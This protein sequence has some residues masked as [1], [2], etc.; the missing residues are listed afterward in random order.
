[1]V[2]DVMLSPI[3]FHNENGPICLPS[4]EH[5]NKVRFASFERGYSYSKGRGQMLAW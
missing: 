1:M 4:R 5:C 2:H 3:R